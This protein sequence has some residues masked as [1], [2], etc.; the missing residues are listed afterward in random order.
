ME[1]K[2]KFRMRKT[3]DKYF[4]KKEFKGKLFSA[5]VCR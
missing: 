2:Y 5:S 4:E 3:A 1:N